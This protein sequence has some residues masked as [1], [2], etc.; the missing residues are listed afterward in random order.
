M[1]E[2]DVCPKCRITFPTRPAIVDYGLGGWTVFFWHQSPPRVQC[3]NCRHVFR[4]EGIRYFGRWDPA[5]FRGALVLAAM[6]A[7]V[8]VATLFLLH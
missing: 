1:S 3:P 2:D 7:A 8:A 6:V 5:Q 4:S